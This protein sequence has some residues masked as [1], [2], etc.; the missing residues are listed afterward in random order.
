MKPAAA[1]RPAAPARTGRPSVR[2]YRWFRLAPIAIVAVL[3][4][5]R[6][7]GDGFGGL[8][9]VAVIVGVGLIEYLRRRN[10]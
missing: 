3:T 1:P 5:V 8:V 7:L 2:S 4:G 10:R 9:V 6:A